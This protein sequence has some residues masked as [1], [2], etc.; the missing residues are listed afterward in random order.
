MKIACTLTRKLVEKK[1]VDAE[2]YDIYCYG[3]N[4]LVWYLINTITVIVIGALSKNLIFL[5]TFFIVYI[6]LRSF[7][8]GIHARTPMTCYICSVVALVVVGVIG[9]Y[10][11]NGYMAIVFILLC[12]IA[13]CLIAP[14]EDE[15]KPLD[16]IERKVYKKRTTII[17]GVYSTIAV[18]SEL[19]NLHFLLK[20]MLYVFVCMLVMLLLGSIKNAFGRKVETRD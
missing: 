3:I 17:I 11:V 13:I 5:F 1:I 7:A 20:V 19:L 18:C 15:N 16:R 8:G 10:E 12:N 4:Q 2:D 6:P 9:S 14:V